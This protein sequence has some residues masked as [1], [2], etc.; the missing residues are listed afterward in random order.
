MAFHNFTWSEI[1][2]IE[3]VSF[4]M[5]YMN[6]LCQCVISISDDLVLKYKYWHVRS[7]QELG[8]EMWDDDKGKNTDL[9][10]ILPLI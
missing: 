1:L 9:E 3:Y 5:F 7:V 2:K 4:L 6:L 10:P 8:F